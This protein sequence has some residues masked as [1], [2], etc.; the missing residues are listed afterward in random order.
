MDNVWRA[1]IGM[2]TDSCESTKVAQEISNYLSA[3]PTIEVHPELDGR[4]L[5]IVHC[6]YNIARHFSRWKVAFSVLI[7]LQILHVHV[8]VLFS[9]AA[10]FST[11]ARAH[12][13]FRRFR[14][15]CNYFR[16]VF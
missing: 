5:D 4:T 3:L 8:H 15:F 13:F 16:H 7:K 10:L 2:H 12:V 1:S 11:R 9:L 6:F 14:C